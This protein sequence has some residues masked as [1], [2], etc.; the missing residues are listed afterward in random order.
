M[1]LWWSWF[2]KEIAYVVIVVVAVVCLTV[3]WIR[4][5]RRRKLRAITQTNM[6]ALHAAHERCVCQFDGRFSPA[7]HLFDT[8]C[9]SV[10]KGDVNGMR[11]TWSELKEE[12]RDLIQKT[13]LRADRHNLRGAC[14]DVLRYMK[15]ICLAHEDV[16]S[17]I[18]HGY[19]P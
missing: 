4:D 10:R 3:W 2:A 15:R 12:Y 13:Y 1:P 14:K 19:G 5:E 6:N 11:H 9:A 16:K 8:F 17:Y 7:G 18:E